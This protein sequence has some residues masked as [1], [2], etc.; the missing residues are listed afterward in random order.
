MA[1]DACN[2]ERFEMYANDTKVLNFQVQDENGEPVSVATAEAMIFVL[3]TAI[4]FDEVLRLEMPTDITIATS[5][6]TVTIPKDTVE[7]GEYVFELQMT[8]AVDHVHTLAQGQG[9]AKR[10]YIA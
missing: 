3:L 6:V 9:T 5:I 10:R 1:I 8:D 4:D 7:A 2:D